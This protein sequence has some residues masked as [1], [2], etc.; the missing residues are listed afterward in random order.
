MPFR[1]RSTALLAKL[2]VG[3][4][5]AAYQAGRALALRAVGG[6]G[7]SLDALASPDDLFGSP[8]STGIARPAGAETPVYHPIGARSRGPSYAAGLA[9][10]PT[11]DSKRDLSRAFR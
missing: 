9:D 2:R 7:G 1:C 4:R 3:Y 11:I 8:C 5:R 6:P 10:S